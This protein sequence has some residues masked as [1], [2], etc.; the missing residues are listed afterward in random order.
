MGSNLA[1]VLR[2]FRTKPKLMQRMVIGYM[3]AF[4]SSSGPM[5]FMDVAVSYDCN[6]SCGHCSAEAL[7]SN[8]SP[9]SIMEYKRIAREAIDCGV[10]AFHFTGGE[11]LL[12]ND[13]L[14]VIDVFQPRKNL[15]SI[16]TNGWFVT[17]DFL[18]AY[19]SIGGDILSVSVDSVTPES[20]DSFRHKEGSWKKAV[21]ALRRGKAFGLRTL[22]AATVTHQSMNDGE[23]EALTKYSRSLGAILSL[24]LAVPAGNWQGC[25]DF[26]LT[27]EDREKLN[28]HITANP[29]VRTDFQSNWRK[30]GC[31]AF[32]EKCYLSP[33]GDVIPCPF[34]HVKFGNVREQSLKDI[35]R[36]ALQQDWLKVYHP[37]CIAAESRE[38][39][40]SAGCYKENLG[41][42]PL[43]YRASQAFHSKV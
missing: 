42:M 39:I 17:D 37:V 3:R 10:M 2:S 19:R 35:R 18:K 29:H 20:H 7:K 40:A 34:I 5:R 41:R 24:N 14:E 25:D 15:I 43:D 31:P 32:K 27:A 13:L 30:R 33:Y 26:I 6:F 22:M 9:L 12:R 36:N 38:F 28:L 23:L 16:Q 11:P 21:R 4:T 8:K 1:F